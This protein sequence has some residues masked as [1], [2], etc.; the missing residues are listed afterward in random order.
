MI[1]YKACFFF[2]SSRRRTICALVTVVQTCAL[3]ICWWPR[4][5]GDF[6]EIIGILS[7]AGLTRA[8]IHPLTRTAGWIAG[9]SPAMTICLYLM[10]FRT[11][12]GGADRK[13][14]VWG[15]SVSVRDAIGGRRVLKKHKYNTETH[16]KQ[17]T[18]K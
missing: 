1:E 3:P 5:G 17:L 16:M 8:S 11:A 10:G 13:S 18:H 9:S 14:V 15:K 6:S 2:S 12:R 7:C 4:S